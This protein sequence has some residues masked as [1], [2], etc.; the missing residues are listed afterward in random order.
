VLRADDLLILQELQD[1]PTETLVLPLEFDMTENPGNATLSIEDTLQ[2]LSK[3]NDLITRYELKNDQDPIENC[4][5]LSS[6]IL[7][8]QDREQ[9]QIII[10]QA[11]HLKILEGF[12]CRQNKFVALSPADLFDY[13]SRKLL[14]L[15][16]QGTNIE[17]RLGL[18]A[19]L[20]KAIEPNVVLINSETAKLVFGNQVDLVSCHANSVLDSLGYESRALQSENSR[21]AL[22][23][24][25]GGA[26]LEGNALRIRGLRYLLHGY[27][28]YFEAD[29]TLWVS[30]Y[31]Q[32]PVWEKLWEQLNSEQESRWNLLN[33]SL[34]EE[35]PSN[36]WRFLSINEIKPEGILDEIRLKGTG[37][38]NGADFTLD[39]RNAVLKQLNNDERLWKAFPFHETVKGE[40][41]NITPGV[42]FLESAI[43][44]PDELHHHA[45]VIKV[46][47]DHAVKNLQQSWLTKLTSKGVIQTVFRHDKPFQFW[48]LVMDHL[49]PDEF[50][51][52]RDSL[53]E[54]KW[55]VDV[56]LNPVKPSDVIGL[57]KMQNEVDRLLTA[58]R[59]VYWSPLKLHEDIRQHSSF[60][61]LEDHCFSTGEEG[62]EKLSLLLDETGEYHVGSLTAPVINL[63]KVINVCSRL[64]VQFNLPGWSLLKNAHENYPPD[65]I[66]KYLISGT[67]KP[68]SIHRIIQLLN[69]FS[70]NHQTADTDTKTDFI[71]GFNAYLSAFVNESGRL[72]DLKKIR[73]LDQEGKW[74]NSNALCAGAEGV[75]ESHLLDNDQK[76]L[77]RKLIVTADVLQVS[78]EGES[79]L[80][81]RDLTPEISASAENLRAFFSDWEGLVAPELICAFLSLLGDDPDM[82]RLAGQ[83][84]GRHSVEWIRENIPWNINRTTDMGRQGW[85]YGLNQHEALAQHRF[86]VNCSDGKTVS[87]SSIIGEEIT[88]PLKSKFSSLITGGLFYE[89]PTGSV[90]NVRIQIRRPSIE[91]TPPSEL[92]ALLRSSTEY[93]LEK[94]YNQTDCDLSTLWEELDKSEQLDIRIAQ[95]LVLNHLPFYLRQLGV[96]KHEKLQDLLKKWNDARYKQEEYYED[97][98]RKKEFEREEREL[99]VQI[100]HLLQT[101]QDVQSERCSFQNSRFSVYSGQYSL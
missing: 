77:L 79:V 59:G 58:A 74:K 94:A 87:I 40:L 29:T 16:S 92:S 68:I 20:K 43:I 67:L 96:H 97:T 57:G 101:D 78:E 54:T 5:T 4:R 86:I 50:L 27:R 42:S 30:G 95:Q 44:L 12:D 32:N 2:I 48:H 25:L 66:E 10:N 51:D 56:D 14:F 64:P 76:K 62:F 23:Q 15:Y 71:A 34:L 11:R 52:F 80:E 3:L 73:L 81:R 99:L 41:V 39:E 35:L 7:K 38:I 84:R 61:F 31:N 69:W 53:K 28:E 24:G 65:L 75:A 45:D 21:Q 63:D 88:V 33:R 47:S 85:L 6:E 72:I 22:I 13:F 90:S 46:S 82:I 98:A 1:C 93:L 8:R 26:D 60:T 49:N 83:Y 9:R 19:K 36:K 18:A 70:D 91:N 37:N 89:Y 55:L 100:Q 17:Q